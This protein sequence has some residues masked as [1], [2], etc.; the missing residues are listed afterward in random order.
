M[1]RAWAVALSSRVAPSAASRLASASASASAFSARATVRVAWPAAWARADDASALMRSASS[2]AAASIVP[3]RRDICRNS[4]PPD[5]CDE[6]LPG[7]LEV[8]PCLQMAR[9]EVLPLASGGGELVLGPADVGVDLEAVV[10]DHDTAEHRSGLEDGGQVTGEV[11]VLTFRRAGAPFC[12][13]CRMGGPVVGMQL[14]G[15]STYLPTHVGSEIPE[16]YGPR[17]DMRP[18]AGRASLG[19]EGTR[20][21]SG[22]RGRCASPCVTCPGR[23][24][25]EATGAR[26][27]TGPRTLGPW[28]PPRPHCLR[29]A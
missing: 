11:G 15:H 2:A 17:R 22:C 4:P 12:L 26:E 18:D 23:V 27:P 3:I 6:Q 28:R 19:G 13:E 5:E 14:G 24:R 29:A 10:A 9:Q 7:F 20:T 25:G 1:R 16:R 21:P 8:G